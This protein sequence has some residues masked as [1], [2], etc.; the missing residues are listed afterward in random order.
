MNHESTVFIVDDDADVQS[1]IHG[2]LT[3]SG[4]RA[5]AFATVEE[6]LAAYAPGT[7][8]CVLVDLRSKDGMSGVELLNE[9]GSRGL[10]LPVLVLS[11]D[12]D[13][14]STV[15]LMRAG[16][17]DVVEKPFDA[18]KLLER[19]R[20]SIA[21]DLASRQHGEHLSVRLASLSARE[22]EV[23]QLL[24][25]AKGTKQIAHH[26]GISPKTVEKHRANVLTKMQADSV[27]ELVRL[28]LP[29]RRTNVAE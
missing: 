27:V 25:A 9:I 15:L 17:I 3:A 23:M 8:G 10:G 11:G 13:V 20:W 26:L 1:A 12:L 18:D 22:R 28:T 14:P 6:F 19:I 29:S 21:Q 5:E 7:P 2:L 16:A 24:V 4:L